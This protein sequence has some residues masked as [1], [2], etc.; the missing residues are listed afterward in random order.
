[1][2]KALIALALVAGCGASEREG[3]NAVAVGEQGGGAAASSPGGTGAGAP[4]KAG[5]AAR[6]T[7]LYEAGAGP[8]KSQLC[9]VE[10]SAGEAQFGI[11]VWGANMLACQGVGTATRTGERLTLE[12]GGDRACRIEATI[13]EGAI[14]LP[15]A[16]SWTSSTGG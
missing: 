3:G 8:Q 2:N 12:M 10:K 4:D 6:L 13:R 7:G 9:M 16:G 15:A 11:I 1:M 14:S 5:T